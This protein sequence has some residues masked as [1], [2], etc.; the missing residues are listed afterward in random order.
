MSWFKRKTQEPQEPSTVMVWNLTTEELEKVANDVKMKVLSSLVECQ[1][2]DP[3]VADDWYDE[4]VCVLKRPIDISPSFYDKNKDA[5]PP[6][7]NTFTFFIMRVT[8]MPASSYL[9]EE[10]ETEKKPA[11]LK[12]VPWTENKTLTFPSDADYQTTSKNEESKLEKE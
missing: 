7:P 11:H 8:G 2:L 9:P 1:A 5:L 3:E 10:P 4:H 6:D 12:E